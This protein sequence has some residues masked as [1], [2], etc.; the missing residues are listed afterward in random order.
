MKELLILVFTIL[1]FAACNNKPATDNTNTDT[2]TGSADIPKVA[3]QAG[4]AAAPM[5][6]GDSPLIQT[7]TRDYWVFEFYID[8]KNRENNRLN[9]GRWYKLNPDGT[10]TNG[11]WEQEIGGGSWVLAKDDMNKDV[12]RLDNRIDSEDAEFQIQFNKE[13]DA[14]SWVGTK[15]FGQSGIMVKAISLM[16]MPTK[17][18]FGVAEEVQ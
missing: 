10:F 15:T 14:A 4:S 1:T 13:A 8:P 12:V 11:H 7:L 16:T 6:P 18:Q 9:K 3:P 5:S 17:A 2:T